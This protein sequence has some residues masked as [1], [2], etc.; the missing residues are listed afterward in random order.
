MDVR[1]LLIGM[2][3][4][5]SS[6]ADKTKGV[7]TPQDSIKF[8]IPYLADIAHS[9]AHPH[10][11]SQG[12]IR[13]YVRNTDTQMAKA[14]VRMRHQK[15]LKIDPVRKTADIEMPPAIK[16]LSAYD[17]TQA[18]LMMLP[19]LFPFQL[20]MKN[21]CRHAMDIELCILSILHFVQLPSLDDTESDRPRQ[22]RLAFHT[23]KG[24]HNLYVCVKNSRYFAAIGAD[25]GVV[26]DGQN[27]SMFPVFNSIRS[28]ADEP[29]MDARF[30]SVVFACR[31]EQGVLR[32]I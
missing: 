22:A 7:S 14:V 8:G 21:L 24:A 4:D 11:K 1:E 9:I 19:R 6:I 3:D 29:S 26:P 13:S 10:Q 16:A 27:V 20:P 25:L 30:P 17:L 31:D 15:L 5:L 32:L 28:A 12:I 18:F 2:R 23:W